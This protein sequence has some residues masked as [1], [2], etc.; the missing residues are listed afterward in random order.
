M[1]RG[2][3]LFLT[4]LTGFTGLVY[5]VTWQRYLA[6]LLGSQSEAAAAVLGI[7]LGG[8]IDASELSQ[9]NALLADGPGDGCPVSP[10]AAERLTRPVALGPC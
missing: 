3:A 5:E 10:E 1:T 7:F 8:R 2:L 6:I 4:V 9:L